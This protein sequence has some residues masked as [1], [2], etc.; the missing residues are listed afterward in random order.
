MELFPLKDLLPWQLR[1][2]RSAQRPGRHIYPVVHARLNF[3]LSSSRTP[4]NRPRIG[5]FPSVFHERPLD[6]LDSSLE[7][8]ASAQIEMVGVCLEV[9]CDLIRGG[10]VGGA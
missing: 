3:G 6:P 2:D 4:G 9:V 8:K 7:V 10:E 5:D 1:H